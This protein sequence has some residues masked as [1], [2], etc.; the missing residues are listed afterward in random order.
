MKKVFVIMAFVAY[1]DASAQDN[2]TPLVKPV[3]PKPKT[4]AVEA[5]RFYVFTPGQPQ[6]A[7][8]GHLVNT[9]PNGNKV[10]ALAQDNMPCVVPDI[11]QYN[12]PVIKPRVE[13]TMPNPALMPPSNKPAILTE[14]QLKKIIEMQKQQH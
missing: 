3:P 5:P 1:V 2:Q 13:Y 12:M 10:Y 6:L 8:K 7:V 11:T 9:L 4:N 14:E